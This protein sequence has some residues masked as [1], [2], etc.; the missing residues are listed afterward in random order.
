MSPPYVGAW[1]ETNEN[2]TAVRR[3]PTIIKRMY[4]A[5]QAV[6]KPNTASKV[7]PFFVW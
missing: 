1:I 7:R 4:F 6:N 3:F 2:S 5:A